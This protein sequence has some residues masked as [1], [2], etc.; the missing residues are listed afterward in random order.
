MSLFTEVI[1]TTIRIKQ[2]F[3][4]HIEFVDPAVMP[5]LTVLG[6]VSSTFS[7]GAIALS[8]T[9]F[10]LT[11]LRITTG[12]VRMTLWFV[13]VTINLT[14]GSNLVTVWLQC[15]DETC[16]RWSLGYNIFSSGKEI[17]PGLWPLMAGGKGMQV[18]V[19]IFCCSSSYSVFGLH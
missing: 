2:G 1:L 16:N 14:M 15:T 12:Y 11:L 9:S 6:R 5:S 3:G 19:L 13:V 7:I 8:K 18:A 17:Y 10:S 4:K